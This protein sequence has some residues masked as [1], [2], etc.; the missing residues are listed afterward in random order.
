MG[1]E[2][3]ER[4]PFVTVFEFQPNTPLTAELVRDRIE[5]QLRV[6]DVLVP[7]FLTGIL[8]AMPRKQLFSAEILNIL[9]SFGN[10]WVDTLVTNQTGLYGPYVWTSEAFNKIHRLYDDFNGSFMVGLNSSGDS[11]SVAPTHPN[12][13]SNSYSACSKIFGS[14]GRLFSLSALPY[15]A[16]QA[17]QR[18]RPSLWLE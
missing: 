13:R 4:S 16:V 14:V 2:H 11:E 7:K 18:R 12:N 9:K 5:T 17:C 1:L 6:D 8:F 10:E 3:L 15:P